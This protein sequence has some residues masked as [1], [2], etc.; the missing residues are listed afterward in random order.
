MAPNTR[1]T[2]AEIFQHLLDNVITDN[3]EQMFRKTMKH[4]GCA[5]IMD[6]NGL[7]VSELPQLKYSDNGN[8]VTPP[9]CFLQVVLLT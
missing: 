6:I 2:Q 8:L 7:G 9:R 5:S 1:K 3:S 4:E